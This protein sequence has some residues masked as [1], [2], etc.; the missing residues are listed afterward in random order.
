MTWRRRPLPT[1]VLDLHQGYHDQN[2]GEA[3]EVKL[4]PGS[5]TVLK[6]PS[7]PT[8]PLSLL[9]GTGSALIPLSCKETG[10]RAY[11]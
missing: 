3:R 1:L 4:S 11:S 10:N 7:L 2:E 8:E 9:T 6:L 5:K